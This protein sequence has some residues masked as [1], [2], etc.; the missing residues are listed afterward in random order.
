M[1]SGWI[2]VDLDATLAFYDGWGGAD[3]IGIPIRPM[4]DRVKAWV[5]AGQ[6]VKIFTARASVPAELRYVREWLERQGI[7][8]LEITNVKDFRMV[9]LYDDR[10]VTVEANTGRILTRGKE[11]G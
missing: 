1:S 9:C 7:G 3:Q 5:A 10:A 6:E 8:G 2:G 4:L 11:E